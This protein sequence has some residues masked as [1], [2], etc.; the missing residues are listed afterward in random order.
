MRYAVVVM[1]ET[2]L[3]PARLRDELIAALEFDHETT[4]RSVV[5]LTTDGKEVAVYDRK[6]KTT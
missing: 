4:A 6:E 3:E 2:D 5:V 1:L